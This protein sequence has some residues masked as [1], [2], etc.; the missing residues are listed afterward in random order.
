MMKDEVVL[1]KNGEIKFKELKEKF[2]LDYTPRSPMKLL[3]YVAST[4]HY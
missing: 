2:I 3:K 4:L 1:E